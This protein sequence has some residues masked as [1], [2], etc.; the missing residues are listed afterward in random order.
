M[1]G[2]VCVWALMD[3]VDSRFSGVSDKFMH[4]SCGLEAMYGCYTREGRS[5]QGLG[6]HQDST[7]LFASL[8]KLGP[9]A[10]I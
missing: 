6:F 8:S 5:D 3:I 10:A 4:F 1:C 7:C 9:R 2:C